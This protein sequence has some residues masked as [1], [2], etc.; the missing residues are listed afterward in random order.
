M[1][2]QPPLD[3][4]PLHQI[5]A[6]PNPPPPQ[7]F[8]PTHKANLTAAS[9]GQAN[10]PVVVNEFDDED[11]EFACDDIDEATLVQAEFSATQAFRASH[12]L[13][14]VPSR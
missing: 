4:R 9:T 1:D 2:G 11:D 7:S 8:N 14:H 3:R 12:P 13:S 10:A 6:H 5:P